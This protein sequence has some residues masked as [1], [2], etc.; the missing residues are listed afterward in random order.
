MRRAI[1]AGL[2]LA[3]GVLLGAMIRPLTAQQGS[4]AACVVGEAS[5]AAC[6]GNWIVFAGNTSAVDNGAWVVRVDTTTGA[7]W[8]RDGND[9]ELLREPE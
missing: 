1:F 5:N 4:A 3:T 8:L 6:A 2:V 7:I 9:M